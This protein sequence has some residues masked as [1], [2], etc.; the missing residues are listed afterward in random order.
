M[1]HC[2]ITYKKKKKHTHIHSSNVLGVVI[3]KEFKTRQVFNF[4]CQIGGQ[5]QVVS[6]THT[7]LK[8]SQ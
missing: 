3:E 1:Q 4:T 6:L 7:L 2:V 8:K 5:F